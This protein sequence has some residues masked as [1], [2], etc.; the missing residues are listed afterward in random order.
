MGKERDGEEGRMSAVRCKVHG[1]G[2]ETA[3]YSLVTTLRDGGSAVIIKGTG[4][5]AAM[6]VETAAAVIYS[7]RLHKISSHGIRTAKHTVDTALERV[8]QR[9]IVEGAI[10]NRATIPA[11]IA[12]SPC[13][14]DGQVVLGEAISA[15][16]HCKRTQATVVRH[17]RTIEIDCVGI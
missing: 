10:G 15:A 4:A 6:D 7:R 13:V 14:R 11:E 12:G 5:C 8:R 17:C 2:V 1:C 9:I 16:K 3:K